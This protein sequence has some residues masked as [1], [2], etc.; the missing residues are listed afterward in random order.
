MRVWHI[1]WC[2]SSFLS[3]VRASR[4]RLICLQSCTAAFQPLITALVKSLLWS[5]SSCDRCCITSSDELSPVSFGIR[6][7]HEFLS[8]EKFDYAFREGDHFLLVPLV[9]LQDVRHSGPILNWNPGG[10]SWYHGCP[11]C[12]ARD[13]R[14]Q[15]SLASLIVGDTHTPSTF[16]HHCVSAGITNL[17]N[18]LIFWLF[19]RLLQQYVIILSDKSIWFYLRWHPI[20]QRP[21]SD[22]RASLCCVSFYWNE[23]KSCSLD[24]VSFPGFFPRETI[25]FLCRKPRASTVPFSEKP[26][27]ITAGQVLVD[28]FLLK[29]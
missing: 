27:T 14:S 28:L 6:T 21:S 19:F 17:P 1:C 5:S 11:G 2:F 18:G 22:V 8:P 4:R 16:F 20:M 29:V 3:S 10:S 26:I 9:S 7:F 25:F 15:R 23:I 13:G 24:S 12:T